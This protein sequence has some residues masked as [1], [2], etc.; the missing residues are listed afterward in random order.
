MKSAKLL[1][2]EKRGKIA[3]K[4]KR[5]AKAKPVGFPEGYLVGCKPITSRLLALRPLA[6]G[7]LERFRS[8]MIERFGDIEFGL[9]GLEQPDHDS[10]VVCIE[11]KTSDRMI[12]RFAAAVRECSP[13]RGIDG[14]V[15]IHAVLCTDVRHHIDEMNHA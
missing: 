7:E 2:A 4:A 13:E 12:K 9:Y 10:L 6:K 8:C 3:A 15:R 14:I 1:A 5:S 11:C